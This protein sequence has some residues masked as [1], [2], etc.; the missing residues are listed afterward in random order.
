MTAEEGLPPSPDFQSHYGFPM[1][2]WIGPD[3][4]GRFRAYDDLAM[5]VIWRDESGRFGVGFFPAPGPE[6]PWDHSLVTID[7]A[8]ASA[9]RCAEYVRE[10]WGLHRSQDD[11]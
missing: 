11:Q 7:D 9:A 6:C 10:V 1:L 8:I 3:E 4:S 5:Y 2:E